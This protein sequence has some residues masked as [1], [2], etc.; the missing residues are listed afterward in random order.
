MHTVGQAVHTLPEGDRVCGVTS[1]GE[2]IYVLRWMRWN[3]RGEV[4]VYDV[5]TYRI[6]RRL[7]VPEALGFTDLASCEHHRC[8]YASDNVA[9]CVH[10]LDIQGAA[11]RWVVNGT[12]WSVSV[13]SAHN[14]MVTCGDLG[15]VKE[16][17]TRGHLLREIALPDDVVNPWHAVMTDAGRLIV[18]NGF[19]YSAVHRVCVLSS[20]GRRVVYSHGGQS[21]S[22]VDQHEM[23]R[24]LAVDGNGSVFVVDIVNRRVTMLSPTL[25]YV[26][27]VVSPRQLKWWPYRLS[28]DARRRRLYVT[29]NEFD[30]GEYKSGRV[31]VFSF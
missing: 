13:N 15:R 8:L 16:F 3:R 25:D 4:E 24:H 6:Q 17:T 12:P 22:D 14:V 27:Q 20:D 2:E 23:P 21:G 19:I 31:V 29:D 18:S 30:A 1:F 11:T 28:L 26:R 5:I 10:R 7:A 9:R